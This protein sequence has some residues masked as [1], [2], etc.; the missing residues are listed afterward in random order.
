MIGKA[1]GIICR[2]CITTFTDNRDYLSNAYQFAYNKDYGQYSDAYDRAFALYQQNLAEE[3][4]RRASASSSSSYRSSNPKKTEDTS[5]TSNKTYITTNYSSPSGDAQDALKKSAV[6]GTAKN[7]KNNV[8]NS[9]YSTSEAK[10]AV[11]DYLNSYTNNSV[12]KRNIL[13]LLG[14]FY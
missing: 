13:N 12:L 10:E 7:I 2:I 4:A 3:N 1:R 5:D 14:L 6:Y 9:G 11:Q 8:I